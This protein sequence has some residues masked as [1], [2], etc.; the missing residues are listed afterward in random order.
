MNYVRRFLRS[1]WPAGT[2]IDQL[3]PST[4]VWTSSATGLVTSTIPCWPIFAMN[5]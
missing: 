2:R 3:G 5:P 1:N 4:G